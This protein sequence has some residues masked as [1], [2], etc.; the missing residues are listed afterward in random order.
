MAFQKWHFANANFISIQQQKIMLMALH[1]NSVSYKDQEIYKNE[2]SFINAIS[3]LVKQNAMR[4]IKD[5]YHPKFELT[6]SGKN[7]VK[8]VMLK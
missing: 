2:R 4:E 1:L 6:E 7:Y 3:G 5:G 8:M